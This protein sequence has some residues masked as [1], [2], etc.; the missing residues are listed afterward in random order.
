MSNTVKIEVTDTGN[1]TA[2][3]ML[4]FNA[5]IRYAE[6]EAL[7]TPVGLDRLISIFQIDSKHPQNGEQQ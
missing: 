7:L 2:N 3:T 1:K 5:C 6:T 4:L